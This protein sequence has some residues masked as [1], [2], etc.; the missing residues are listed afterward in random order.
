VTF[1]ELTDLWREMSQI[2]LR[3]R[4]QRAQFPKIG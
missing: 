1:G 4:Q 2:L 3:L